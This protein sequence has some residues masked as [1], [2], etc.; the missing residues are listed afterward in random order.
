MGRKTFES[1]GKPLPNRKNIV[2]SRSP[3]AFSA[4]P[5]VQIV[6]NPCKYDWSIYEDIFVIGGAEIYRLFLPYIATFYITQF[7]HTA[8]QADVFLPDMPNFKLSEIILDRPN[9]QIQKWDSLVEKA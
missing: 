9:F 4:F 7:N 6:E 5:T 3:A 8:E 2:I 1:I